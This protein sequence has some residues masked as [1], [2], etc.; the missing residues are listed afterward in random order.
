MI[1]GLLP[2]TGG[3]AHMNLSARFA[4]PVLTVAALALSGC[5]A[6]G[7]GAKPEENAVVHSSTADDAARL[8]DT[9][10]VSADNVRLYVNGMGCPQCVSNIDLQLAK[11]SGVKSTRVNL[12]NGTVDVELY[13]KN[14][15]SPA[16]INRAVSGDFTL[17][18]I[19]ELASGAGVGQ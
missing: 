9:N 16:Q 4:F 11:L 10:A 18:K 17:I 1:A 15:P 14:R 13:A 7:G 2:Q 12:A 19:E 3:K 6:P 8:K 5:A